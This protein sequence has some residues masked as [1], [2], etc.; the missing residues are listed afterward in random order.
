MIPKQRASDV[1]DKIK[2]QESYSLTQT[3]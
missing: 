1:V 2:L 3:V